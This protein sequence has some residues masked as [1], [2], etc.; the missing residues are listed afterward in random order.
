MQSI[1][2]SFGKDIPNHL[3]TAGYRR[4]FDDGYKWY[5]NN[6]LGVLDEDEND[7]YFASLCPECGDL[8]ITK[9]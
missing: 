2:E 4:G 7:V 8:I 6:H 5:R 1:C 3:V 9:E